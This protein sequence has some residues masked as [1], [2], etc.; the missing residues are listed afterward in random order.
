MPSLLCPVN[1]PHPLGSSSV[2]PPL[3]LLCY[4]PARGVDIAACDMGIYCCKGESRCEV[5]GLCWGQDGSPLHDAEVVLERGEVRWDKI[6]ISRLSYTCRLRGRQ[7]GR[8]CVSWALDSRLLWGGVFV[9]FPFVF[10]WGFN[11]IFLLSVSRVTAHPCLL[12][13]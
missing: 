1:F 11:Q 9:F 13:Q 10:L 4:P 3:W 6:L 8:L 5:Q 7:A 2:S 12:C